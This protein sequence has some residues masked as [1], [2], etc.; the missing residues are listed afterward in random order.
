MNFFPDFAPN[1]RNLPKILN[2]VKINKLLIIIHYYSKLFTGVITSGSFRGQ[3]AVHVGGAA[4]RRRPV[5]PE[6]GLAVRGAFRGPGE[7]ELQGDADLPSQVPIRGF[8]ENQNI[9]MT[10]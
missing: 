4:Q 1:S 2:F 8:G 3:H 10:L 5:A 7:V 6:R 9:R